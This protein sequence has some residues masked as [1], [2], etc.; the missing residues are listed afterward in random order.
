MAIQG[1]GLDTNVISELRKQDNAHPGV[2]RF[3]QHA[4]AHN[5]PLFISVITVGE[6]R[7]T[8][9][10]RDFAGTGVTVMNPFG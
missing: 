7:V 9:N 8:R 6:L 1:S 3:F 2:Q 4:D 10:E 5:A